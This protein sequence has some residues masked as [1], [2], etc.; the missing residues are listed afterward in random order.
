MSSSANHIE[1]NEH[2]DDDSCAEDESEKP[3]TPIEGEKDGE[4]PFETLEYSTTHIGRKKN[5]IKSFE[6]ELETNCD[7]KC[8]EEEIHCESIKVEING[9]ESGTSL[10][11][12]ESCKDSKENETTESDYSATV[13][14]SGIDVNSCKS[15]GV[16]ILLSKEGG[17]KVAE[18][19]ELE[20]DSNDK[21]ISITGRNYNYVDRKNPFLDEI[22]D[23]SLSVV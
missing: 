23:E 20:D 19:M 21:N 6:N 22:F 4:N 9:I 8:I 16:K 13:E 1:S 2:D 5:E 14:T 18:N 7:M 12:D 3:G 11:D 15:D 10:N 17:V